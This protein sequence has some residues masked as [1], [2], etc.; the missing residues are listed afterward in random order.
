MICPGMV[1]FI[2]LGA[3]YLVFAK[4]C[5]LWTDFFFF[6]LVVV[7]FLKHLGHYE[8]SASYFLFSPFGTPNTHIVSLKF[9]EVA[10][11]LFIFFSLFFTVSFS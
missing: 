5:N 7:K 8:F 3:C 4:L 9:P 2:L 1:F 6:F 11:A 10:Y